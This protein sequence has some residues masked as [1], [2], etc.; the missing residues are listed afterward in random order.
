MPRPSRTKDRSGRRTKRRG[1]AFEPLESRLFLVADPVIS[2]F[3]A[4]NDQTLADQDGDFSDWIE[5]HNPGTAAVDLAGWHLTNNPTDLDLW[6]FPSASVPANGYLVVFASAKNRAAAG[7]ELHTNFKL[8]GAGQYLALVRPDGTTIAREFAPQYPEQAADF[9]YGIAMQSATVTLVAPEA[10]ASVL[11]PTDGSLGMTWIDP[12]FIPGANWTSGTTG[13][14]YERQ[15]GYESLINVDVDAAMYN[16]NGS[17]YIIIP[18]NVD[19]S[20][21]LTELTLR[22]K[23]DDGYVA[24]LNGEKIAER[25]PPTT[26]AWNSLSS[27]GRADSAAVV[28]EDA[29]VSA[30][31]N[32]LRVGTNVLAIQGLNTP[33][34]SSDFVIMPELVGLASMSLDPP[35]YGYMAQATPGAANGA[36]F[37]GFVADTQ[38][39]QDRGFFDA[40]FDVAITCATPEAV[41]RYTTDGSTPTATTGAVYAGPIMVSATT[42]LRAAAFKADFRPSNVDTQTYLFLAGVPGQSQPAGYPSSWSGIPADYGVDPEVL[43]NPLYAG[44]LTDAL[45]SLPT[46]SI[47][48]DQANLF[49][50]SGVYS[51]PTQEGVAWERPASAELIYPDGRQGFQIDAGLRVQGGASRDSANSPKHSLRLLFK[52]DYGA[53]K[54]RFPLFGDTAATSFDTIILRAGYNN[55]WIHWD[56]AQRA[57]SQY[58]RDQF[59]RD[60]QLAMGEPAAHGDY[61]HLYING[62]YWGLYNPSERPEASFAAD[63]LGGAKEQYDA[64]NSAVVVDGDKTAWN[65]MMGLA[66]A[67]LA[68]PAQYEAIQQYLDVPNLIDFMILNF[69]GGNWDWDDHNWYAVRKREPG[70]GYKF[71]AWDSER[72][73]EGIN[74]NRIGVNQNDRPSRLF[75]QLRANAEFKLLFA[76]HVQRHFFNG[77]ALTPEVAAAR[78]TARSSE[79]EAAVLAES[80]RWGDYRR[81]VD[82][83]SNG[84]YELYT[85]AT[86]WTVERNRLLSQYFPQRSAAVLAQFRAAGLFPAVDAPTMS[87]HGGTIEPGFSFTLSAPAGTIYY[88]LDGSDPRLPGGA[89][90]PAAQAYTGPVLL[91]ESRL[92]KA[93]VLSGSAW[94]AVNE[95][96]FVLN[97]PLPVRVTEILYHPQAP[98]AG[99]PY[100][101]EDFEFIELVNTGAKTIDLAGVRFTQGITFD[102]T[103]DDVASL[104]PGQ[105]VLVVGNRPAF[106]S[107]YGAGL[108][109]AGQYTGRLNNAGETIRLEDKFGVPV[110]E[111]AYKDGWH[112]LTDTQGFSLTLVDPTADPAT[113]GNQESW[114]PSR[115]AGGSPGTADPGL[116]LPPGTVVINELVSNHSAG[117]AA[118]D[119]IELY[120]TTAASIDVGGWFLS[121]DATDL[122]KY[123]IA[124][125]M[126]IAA[127]GYLVLTEA[128]H[129][130]NPGDPGMKTPFGFNK[131]RDRVYL[132]AGLADGTLLGYQE[133]VDFGAAVNDVPFG[134]YV[135]STG[136]TDFVAL[137]AATPGEANAYP[138]VGPIVIDR[139]MYH[140]LDGDDEFIELANASAADVALFDPNN[141]ANTWQLADAVTFAFPPGVVVPAHGRVLVV[142]ID[143]A[144]FRTKYAIPA[145][146]QIVGPYLGDLNNAGE[147][148]DLDRPDT[149]DLDGFVPMIRVDHVNYEPLAPWPT[150]PDG[151]GPALARA[152]TID[153]GN[154]P[155]NWVASDATAVA[156][157]GNTVNGGAVQ[158]AIVSTLA[159][160]FGAD[161]SASLG[162]GD[163]V[164]TNDTE[165]NA[166]D[167]SALAPVYDAATNTATWNLA[168]AA[169]ADGWYTARLLSAGVTDAAGNHL[170]GD[171]NG[172]PG[173]NYRA[174]FFRLAGDTNGDAS[175]DIF[176]VAALQPNYGQTSG[177]TPGEGDFDGDGDVDIFD[178][179][180]LQTQ[181]CKTLAAPA[182]M[183]AAAPEATPEPAAMPA[184]APGPSQEDT[185]DSCAALSEP[186]WQMEAVSLTPAV[187]ESD[188]DLLARDA[189]PRAAKQ[190][191]RVR[192]QRAPASLRLAAHAAWASA[193]DRV[194]ESVARVERPGF[195]ESAA[196]AASTR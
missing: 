30:Y 153:Y 47:V 138:R 132:T 85:P 148:L 59:A 125:G 4:V 192:P 86:H 146:V 152:A 150:T 49:G 172:V 188:L 10:P 119:W 114:R 29:D 76:D 123:Q 117:Q 157:L 54:L 11:V 55:S 181:Y 166:I 145:E 26:L 92:V 46:L 35:V 45:R 21:S 178:V 164:L 79:I 74:D 107:R 40:P 104:A 134:R 136:N 28:Y 155:A 171:G 1:L 50:A 179:A 27:A 82:P 149:P 103:G 63:Y 135:K 53:T 95:A 156:V 41:I 193:V 182:G 37:S 2:E 97:T 57:R 162:S 185:P 180:I 116:L 8:D 83:R 32:K 105:Y 90:S 113:W 70:A 91:D 99:S 126:T 61:V 154:D 31:L 147:H 129:F 160:R 175:V 102:F 81:D 140:P 195:G 173:D 58:I 112:P 163:L 174:A 5:I 139:I 176:D 115:L 191:V 56:S 3:M 108:P 133:S 17:A 96:T 66:N 23:Y 110:L 131:L 190:A 151:A 67:G 142:P 196:V 143:P 72:T 42:T 189:R 64:L 106:E 6:E 194:I 9:S 141:P 36:A 18:F 158:R 165:G 169:L 161:V 177:M 101:T 38:F 73:L 130:A 170:D 80:A 60:T 77:G 48:T 39:N 122:E 120:N 124:A 159:I 89:V 118:G 34:N 68:T 168:G 137:A 14:G 98:P 109:V 84:P 184:S 22:M 183:P 43:N 127:G 19:A 111:F 62:L 69:Y 20:T 100:L 65:T 24:F 167:V 12:D 25:N 186:S 93:R 13:V 16:K 94:S 52:D 44:K 51:N 7:A 87:R 187:S 71:F 121:Q 144:A 15:T 33:L 78:W 75:Q 128:G 88:T